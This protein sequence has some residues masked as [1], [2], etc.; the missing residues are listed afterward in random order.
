MRTVSY[1]EKIEGKLCIALG[2]FDGVHLGHRKILEK[3]CERAEE[4]GYVKA[5][6]TFADSPK[7]GDTILTYHDRKKLFDTLDMDF[8][9]PL[10]FLREGR[11][12]GEAFFEELTSSY[13]VKELVCGADYKF[14]CDICDVAKLKLMCAQKGIKL[15][16]VEL[17]DLESVRVSSTAIKIF[18]KTGK[19]RAANKMLGMP[20]HMTERIV[21]GHGIGRNIGIPTVNIGMPS[22]MI[23]L[24]HG[25]YGTKV[26]L[27]GK[28]YDAVTN[29]GTK[30]TF[31]FNDFAIE[32][33]LIGYS[34]GKSLVGSDITVYFL[35]YLRQTRKFKSA[36]ELVS[37]IQKDMRWQ[38]DVENRTKR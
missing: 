7:K 20:Y 37:Q 28:V 12:T 31:D 17:L 24:K 23:P 32:S 6:L 10:Y 34:G 27:E 2:Y 16:V 1:R 14:G 33:Y 3:V 25:V 4:C 13:D 30:P 38:E 21:S 11:K 29:F 26:E 15:I 18:L 35:E 5:V 36:A 22:G 19:L 8:C 9:I